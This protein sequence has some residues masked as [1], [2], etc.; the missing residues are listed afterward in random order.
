MASI[1]RRKT[2][3]GENRW[4]VRYRAPDGRERSRT[5]RT[6]RD[7]EKYASTAEADKARGSWIDPRDAALTFGEVADRWLA[8][9]PTKR[10]S[11][12]ATDDVMLR[13]HI[14]PTLGERKVGSVARADV[15]ALVNAWSAGSAP[16]TVR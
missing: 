12:L 13:V 9:N 11:T 4:E 2:T 16:R 14:L 7:A 3:N 6:R 8:S 10:A 5:F 15:Q 1:D